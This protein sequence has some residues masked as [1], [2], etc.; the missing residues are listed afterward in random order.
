LGQNKSNT[1]EIHL[2]NSQLSL[3]IWARPTFFFPGQPTRAP[4]LSPLPPSPAASRVPRVSDPTPPAPAQNRAN[5]PRAPRPGRCQPGHGR[6]T[7]R[8]CSKQTL[9][10]VLTPEPHCLPLFPSAVRPSAFKSRRSPSHPPF[11]STPSRPRSSMPPPPPSSLASVH[12]L[13][14]PGLPLPSLNSAE[15]WSPFISSVSR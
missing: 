5:R 15:P 13:G 4:R 14:M 8:S 7:A 11:H 2:N 1:F 6:G 12:W 10:W 9:E 3:F